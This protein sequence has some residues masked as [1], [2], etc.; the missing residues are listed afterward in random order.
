MPN[1]RLSWDV[2]GHGDRLTFAARS[3]AHAAELLPVVQEL[4]RRAGMQRFVI[5]GRGDRYVAGWQG[6]SARP[7]GAAQSDLGLD[8]AEGAER[9]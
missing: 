5:R 6:Q 7:E 9:S 8:R 3:D 1:Y 4:G 2:R